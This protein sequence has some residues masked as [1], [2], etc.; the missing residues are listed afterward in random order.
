MIKNEVI[1]L[2]IAAHSQR[3]LGYYQLHLPLQGEPCQADFLLSEFEMRENVCANGSCY[4]E[5]ISHS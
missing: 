2:K 3:K 5:P 1:V 4:Q